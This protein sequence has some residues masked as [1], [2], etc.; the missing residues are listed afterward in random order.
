MLDKYQPIATVAVR[1]IATAAKFYE[2]VLGLKRVANESGEAYSYA[3]GSVRLI[4]YRS[5]F[6][7]TNQA[8]AVTW[9]IESGVDELVKSLEAK[10]VTFED[11]D[12][13]HVRREGHIHVAGTQRVAWFKD[14]DGNIHALAQGANER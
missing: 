3:A 10:G 6:A 8:T 14:P 7:G 11:Y 1:D 4:V 13:P 5:Q 2:D 12:M 9:S